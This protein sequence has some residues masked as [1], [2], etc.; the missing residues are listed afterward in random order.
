MGILDFEMFNAGH[1]AQQAIKNPDQMLL[2]AADPFG[3]KVWG[4]IT[5]RNYEPI[6]NQWGGASDGAYKAAEARGI[7]TGAA[8][9]AHQVAQSI[10]GIFAGGA[11]GGAMGAGGSAASGGTAATGAGAASAGAGSTGAAASGGSGLLSTANNVMG[12]AATTG[13]LGNRQQAP[14]AQAAALPGRQADFTGLLSANGMNQ[15]SGADKLIAQ[16]AARQG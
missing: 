6:V 12:L 1:M 5:G 14:Q 15:M 8:K 9:G 11:L 13:A 16:R 2:G 3:A 7:E 4:G 10:A